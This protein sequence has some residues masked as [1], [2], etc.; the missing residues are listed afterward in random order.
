MDYMSMIVTTPD[1]H[2][3]EISTDPFKRSVLESFGM[4]DCKPAATPVT[5]QLFKD[6]KADTEAGKFL[7]ADGVRYI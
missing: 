1:D 2:C 4:T 6:I 7:D 3:I 5:K